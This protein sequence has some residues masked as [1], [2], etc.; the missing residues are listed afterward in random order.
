MSAIGR[1]P[2][3]TVYTRQGCG[4]CREAEAVVAEEARGRAEVRLVD[5][6]G[7]AE[8]SERYTVRVPVVA[9]DGV[10]LFDFQVDRELLA[11]TLARAAQV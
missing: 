1:T 10:E 11:Q 2:V 4:L 8:L 5:I 3:V 9:V 7:D 6:D